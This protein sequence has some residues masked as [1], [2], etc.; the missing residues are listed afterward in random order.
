MQGTNYEMCVAKLEVTFIILNKIFHRVGNLI[1]S[2][3]YVNFV[4]WGY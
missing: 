4:K 3:S 1:F 2:V